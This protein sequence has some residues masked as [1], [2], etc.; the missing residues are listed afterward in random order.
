MKARSV[1]TFIL[2]ATSSA[3]TWATPYRAE[4]AVSFMDLPGGARVTGILGEWHF[5][6][7]ETAGHPLAE[8]AFLERSGSLSVIHAISEFD[9]VDA[10]ATVFNLGYYIPNTML[11]VGATHQRSSVDAGNF[12]FSENDW[13][14]TF[15][16][17]PIEGLLIS[18]EYMDEPGY[19]FNLTAK[20]L[21]KLAGDTAVNFDVSFIKGEEDEL[22]GEDGEDQKSFAVD[23]YL[24]QKV[25]IGTVISHSYDTEFG[26]RTQA[27]FTDAFYVGAEYVTASS[28]SVVTLV[29]GLRF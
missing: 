19:N 14:L 17:A 1:C 10:D 26:L 20:Y 7:V 25:S 18:T 13:G 12:S 6:P 21:R 9:W 28:E 3:L 5:A 2:M 4:V 27:F 24:N 22:F 29:A 11:F 8:A 15:G 16:V 23:Y